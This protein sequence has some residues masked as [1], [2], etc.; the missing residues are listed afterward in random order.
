MYKLNVQSCKLD[1][2]KYM[3]A[4]TQI[5][6]TKIFAF[7]AILVFSLLSHKVLF[8]NGKDDRNCLKLLFREVNHVRLH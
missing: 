5:T 1:D 4:S 7:I 6:D 2:D 8:I 3:I